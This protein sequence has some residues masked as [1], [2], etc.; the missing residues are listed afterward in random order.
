MS[1]RNDKFGGEA[2]SILCGL[3]DRSNLN[4]IA[5]VLNTGGQTVEQF[6]R[7]E[8]VEE[9]RAK[10]VIGGFELEQVIDGDG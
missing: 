9:V 3:G 4:L 8:F 6:E 5:E 7:I 10:F 1:G 2:A